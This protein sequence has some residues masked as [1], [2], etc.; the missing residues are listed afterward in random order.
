MD[1]TPEE[2]LAFAFRQYARTIQEVGQERAMELLQGVFT[3]ELG[4]VTQEELRPH[5]AFL[6]RH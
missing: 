2:R 5:T 6:V 4:P 3:G 1:R